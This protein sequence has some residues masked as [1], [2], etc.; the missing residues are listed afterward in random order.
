M[1]RAILLTLVDGGGGG[2]WNPLSLSPVEWYDFSDIATLFQD[3]ART[4]AVTT[5]GQSIKGVAD[6]SGNSN[7]LSQATN[8]P[9]YKTSIQNSLSV[10]RFDGLNDVLTMPNLTAAPITFF[11]AYR[12]LNMSA[13]RGILSH[14]FGGANRLGFAY[15]QTDNKLIVSASDGTDF[16]SKAST[17]VAAGI[18]EFYYQ[19][20]AG[21]RASLAAT[22]NGV[23]G[24]VEV[25]PYSMV[26]TN[27][28]TLGEISTVFA[29]CDVCEVVA[30]SRQ[31]T[32]NEATQLR[33][34]LNEKWALF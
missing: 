16:A 32:A 1:N 21:N 17:G 33:T 6:K 24:S 3:T 19:F 7:H 30:I 8:P 5:D 28:H 10:A 29:L 26:N 31:L 25:V 34:Y 9:T 27:A 13:T 22:F 23:A 20:G 14:N 18:V 4:S 2:A 15:R 11:V 12:G